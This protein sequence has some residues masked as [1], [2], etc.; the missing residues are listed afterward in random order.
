MAEEPRQEQT[1]PEET[2]VG[3]AILALYERYEKKSGKEEHM[4]V[5]EELIEDSKAAFRTKPDVDW[6]ALAGKAIARQ[7]GIEVLFLADA[8][9]GRLDEMADWLGANLEVRAESPANLPEPPAQMPE[10]KSGYLA[11]LAKRLASLGFTVVRDTIR[12]DEYLHAYYVLCGQG[13]ATIYIYISTRAFI[14]C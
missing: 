1:V 2:P 4:Q 8:L 3:K 12:S 5:L 7:G 13:P 11:Q 14:D 6:D 9:Q 10:F